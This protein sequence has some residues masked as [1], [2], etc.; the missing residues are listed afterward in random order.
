LFAIG[1]ALC[2]VQLYAHLGRIRWQRVFGWCALGVLLGEIAVATHIAPSMVS[3]GLSHVLAA[4]SVGALI[5]ILWIVGG[6][7]AAR[8]ASEGALRERERRLAL[9]AATDSLTG[10]GN[11]AAFVD[12]LNSTRDV[13]EP[14]AIAF[15]D[16]N[17]FKDVNDTYGHQVGDEVLIEVASRLRRVIRPE[18]LAARVGGDEFAILVRA[19]VDDGSATK[20]LQRLRDVLAEPWEMIA[21]NSVSA[22]VGVV[23]DLEGTRTADD[24]MRDADEQMYARKHGMSSG[25]IT[26]MTSRALAHHRRAMDG[27]RASFAV[28]RAIR[29]DGTVVDWEVVEANAILRRR[30]E[31]YFDDLVGLRFSE[32]NAYVDGSAFVN[33]ANTAVASGTSETAEFERRLPDGTVLWNNA[34]AVPVD[35]DIVAIMSIDVTAEVQGRQALERERA[36]FASLVDGSS[37]LACVVDAQGRIVYTP[38]WSSKFLGYHMN[39]LDRPL[40]AV[41]PVD[42]ARA[43]NWFAIACLQAPDEI[44]TVTLHFFTSDGTP[45]TCEVSAQNRLDNPLVGGIVLTVR[46]VSALVG[47]EA[48]LTAIAE[49]VNDVLAIC[50]ETGV[51]TWASG[52]IEDAIGMRAEDV[53]GRSAFSLIHPDDHH[54]VALR[55]AD[56]VSGSDEQIPLELRLGNTDGTYRWFD[57]SGNNRL[58]DPNVRGIVVSLRDITERRA[59]V[60]ALERSEERNR[61]IVEAAGDAII[62]VDPGG[63]IASFN[64][65]AERIFEV[66]VQDAIGSTYNRFLPD[67]SLAALRGALDENGVGSQISVIA[68]RASGERFPAEV[69]ISRVD[70]EG[71]PFF[72]AV[73]RD[74]SEQ[75]RIND[76]LRTAAVRDDLTGLCNRRS[77]LERTEQALAHA[78]RVDGVV[79]MI[80]VNLDRFKLVNDGLGHD[81][82]DDVLIEVANRITTAVRSDDIVARLGSDEFA[83]LCPNAAGLSAVTAAAERI[84]EALHR[85]F[86]IAGTE[87]YIGASTGVSTWNGER[88]SLDLLRCADVAMHRAKDAS[89]SHVELF[90]DEMQREVEHRLEVESALRRALDRDEFVV[91]YQPVVDLDS[92]QVQLLEALVRWNRPGHGVVSPDRFIGVAEDCGIIID[93]GAQVLR[94]AIADCAGWQQVAPGVGVSVNVSARQFDVSELDEH[95]F[96]ALESSGL[97]PEL[98]T[99]EIT[100]SVMLHHTERNVAMMQRFRSAGI[101]LTLDDFGTGFS[102]LTHVRRLPIDGIK[103]DRSFLESLNPKR[104]SALLQSMVDLGRSQEL[105]VIA[106]GIDSRDKLTAVRAAG[107][108]LGQGFLFTKPLPLDEIVTLV[109]VERAMSGAE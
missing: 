16:I 108:G 95:V 69:S 53:V 96:D 35:R 76:A 14:I 42:R 50:D 44:T 59:V 47:L 91:H 17:D 5:I 3:P 64:R 52:A 56:V 86:V 84:V 90:D 34:S 40:F 88:S 7:F 18:D 25:A 21:P 8:D 105:T 109:S 67:A 4:T 29:D 33:L 101:H 46:D 37:D 39:E 85:P 68:K 71:L 102:S 74:V 63:Q 26:T 73:V 79:G 81:V 72:T 23:Q 30:F 13:G 93:L 24:L 62:T 11:R 38:S 15:V 6:V 36:R 60:E 9:E 83:V 65:A 78:E 49:S 94:R 22:G 97:T 45:R 55:L 77:L 87:V 70:V 100:E 31:P 75:R 106:E 61:S 57:C 104:D 28:V 89:V 58:D 32:M 48:R 43:A 2:G 99:L 19:A 82:G 10:L 1:Y 80:F 98:L 51:L 27:M 41:A 103:I 92:G 107:C 12:T 20:L 66:G 54:A